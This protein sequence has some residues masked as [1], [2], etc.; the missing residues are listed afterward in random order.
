[1]I[2]YRAILTMRSRAT[3]SRRR[4]RTG[5]WKT[6]DIVNIDYEGKID[7]VAFEGGTAQGYDLTIGSGTLLTDLK[8]D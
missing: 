3:W 5:R 2:I 8:T 7:G 6:G 4:S 1:M